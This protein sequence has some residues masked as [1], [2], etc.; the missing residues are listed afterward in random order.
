M[1]CLLRSGAA[2]GR[3]GDQRSREREQDDEREEEQKNSSL[4]ESLR[5]AMGDSDTHTQAQGPPERA[6]RCRSVVVGLLRSGTAVA[7]VRHE[8]CREREQTDRKHDERAV[9]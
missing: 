7:C 8:R 9:Q 1:A 6:L 4:H 2:A 5:W 3:I